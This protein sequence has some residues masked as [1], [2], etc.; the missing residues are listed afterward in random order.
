[1]AAKDGHISSKRKTTYIKYLRS[2]LELYYN[3][4]LYIASEIG[5]NKS[6]MEPDCHIQSNS[7]LHEVLS[8]E[9]MRSKNVHFFKFV[10]PSCIEK[11][12]IKP[13]S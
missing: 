8:M 7:L 9:F 6:F 5:V 4:S 3:S 11:R 10:A 13:Q 1:V 12:Y 2:L